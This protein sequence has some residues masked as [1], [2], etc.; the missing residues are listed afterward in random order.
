MLRSCAARLRPL[1]VAHGRPGG[2][3]L[4]V[5]DRG[6]E[7][8]FSFEE[9]TQ[10]D[11]A[12]PKPSWSKD[13]R[14]LFDQF[15]KKCED[16]SWERLPSYS[17]HSVQRFQNFTKAFFS[18]SIPV[19]EEQISQAKF[20][21]RSFEDGLGFEYAMFWSKDEKRIVCLFQGGL[22]LQG[23]PGFLHGGALVTLIDTTLGMHAML[24]GGAVMT[25]NLSIN[26]KR[27]MPLCSV[28]VIN[29][30]L[31]KI[32]GRKLFVSCNIQS[33]DEKTVYT[34]GTGLFI[35][36]EPGKTLV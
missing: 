1:L 27:P 2:A 17:R 20:F 25:A 10:K 30:Q 24:A 9:V 35:K 7:S 8:T 6:S 19:K 18:G 31:D 4:T 32:E 29:T 3:R 15:M 23:I 13:L 28:G 36:L 16:G 5:R 21:P 12:L 34:E 22:Y 26:F 11:H 33:V 14:L